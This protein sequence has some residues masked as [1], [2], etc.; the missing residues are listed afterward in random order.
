MA[1]QR[2]EALN[3]LPICY[4]EGELMA[5]FNEL[6]VRDGV[7]PWHVN[8]FRVFI[9]PPH[10]RRMPTGR[11]LI[12]AMHDLMDKETA[13]VDLLSY[14]WRGEKTL[15]F[16]GVARL[17]PFSRLGFDHLLEYKLP[18]WHSDSVGLPV[19]PTLQSFTAQ[20]LKRNF[21]NG[22]DA[23]IRNA[24][25]QYIQ[26]DARRL[27]DWRRRVNRPHPGH[28]DTAIEEIER[29]MENRTIDTAE[30]AAK[31][32]KAI[33]EKLCDHAVF[34]NQHHFLAGRR[35]FRMARPSDLNL[36]DMDYK[37][38]GVR[39]AIAD[40]WVFET[41]AVER[42]SRWEFLAPTEG[43]M[44]GDTKMLRPV[45]VQMCTKTANVF[46]KM[47]GT[48]DVQQINLWTESGVM[49]DPVYHA[50]AKRHVQLLPR[51]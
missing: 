47:V 39:G 51:Q 15:S 37:R 8:Y 33:L 5:A 10:K 44:G 36:T 28:R 41:A 32:Q 1:P 24:V 25:R 18:P 17:R 49:R 16:K 35:S 12:L 21:E 7:G 40:L 50:I 2:Y 14:K 20:T 22:D 13:G 43:L 30:E 45:W 23:S 11:E 26:N 31:L 3:L 34:I 27:S 46:G 29:W 19:T 6:P 9:A 48:V 42:F 4:D 38:A